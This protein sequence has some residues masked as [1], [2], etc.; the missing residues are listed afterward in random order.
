MIKRFKE[1]NESISGTEFVGSF[2]PNYGDTKIKNKTISSNDTS[3]IYSDLTG[4]IYTHDDYN[5]IYQEYLK[6]G[7]EPLHGFN[8]ENLD[9]ILTFTAWFKK[10]INYL[11]SYI[12]SENNSISLT[13]DALA[14]I[15]TSI[16]ELQEY[17]PV[18]PTPTL[19][20]AFEKVPKLICE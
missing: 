20:S 2:G 3:V 18:T 6:I 16:V 8:R 11:I 13:F 17:V 5:S 7:G 14:V 9:I 15:S 1:F 10:V 12:F 4:E 19:K